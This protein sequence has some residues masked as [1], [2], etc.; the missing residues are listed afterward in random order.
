MSQID[1]NASRPHIMIFGLKGIFLEQFIFDTILYE[2]A[3]TKIRMQSLPKWQ[4]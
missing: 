1:D 3:C 2:M 4:K